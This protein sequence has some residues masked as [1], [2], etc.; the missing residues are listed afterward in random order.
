ME[1]KWEKRFSQT[2]CSELRVNLENIYMLC[3]RFHTLQFNS[4]E[5]YNSAIL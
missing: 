3:K 4:S 2:G 5:A 1:I